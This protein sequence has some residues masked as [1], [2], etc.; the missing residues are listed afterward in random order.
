ML[1]SIQFILVYS[2]TTGVST[3]DPHWLHECSSLTV[4]SAREICECSTV[5]QRSQDLEQRKSKQ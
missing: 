1:V 5:Y 4:R 3:A 2:E